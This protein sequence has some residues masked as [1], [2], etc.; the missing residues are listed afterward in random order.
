MTGHDADGP[1]QDRRD[2]SSS[3]RL[4]RVLVDQLPALMAY[5]DRDGRNV[6]ANA[7]YLEWFGHAPEDMVGLHISEVLGSDVYAKNLPF[8]NGALAGVE[9][10]FDRTLVDMVGQERHTQASYMPDVVDGD[11]RGFFVLVA[12]VT[13][14]VLAQRAMDEAQALARVGSWALTVATGEVSFSDELKRMVGVDATTSEM[15]IGVLS[16]LIHPEDRQR[17]LDN[18]AEASRT[19]ASYAIGYRVVRPDGAVVEVLSQGQPVCDAHGAV[20]RMSGT[21]QDVTE[22]NRAARALARINGELREANR[23]NSDVI[24][25][26][27]HDIGAPLTAIF[28]LSMLLVDDWEVLDE[29]RRRATVGRIAG[30]AGR[31]KGMVQSILALAA[32]DSG[33]IQPVQS[34]VDLALV[35]QELLTDLPDGDRV[36]VVVDAEVPPVRFDR[37]HLTQVV[38]NLVT[39]AF[40]YGA[41]PVRVVVSAD[42]GEGVRLAVRDAGAGVP[43]DAV[44]TLFDRFGRTGEAQRRAGGTGFGLYVA[45]RLA[46]ANSAAVAYR[47]AHGGEPHGFV[48]TFADDAG[49]GDEA[50]ADDRAGQEVPERAS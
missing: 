32:V 6:V 42:D 1:D 34:E 26:L 33:S 27:G 10:H 23:L 11:V 47:P 31:M 29:D 50:P 4:L 41:E 7:A 12:D 25:M 39:N 44:A 46:A 49:R 43:D 15:S 36:E 37:F 14:R 17:V 22:S 16:V 35:L 48:L 38:T 9:Q 28:G 20:V 13:P 18:L 30:A 24:G 40:R 21:M 2:G 8:I 19:S 3:E 5:W 45:G